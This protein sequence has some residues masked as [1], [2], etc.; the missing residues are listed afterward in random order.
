[1]LTEAIENQIYFSY[2]LLE[3]SVPPPWGDIWV[4]LQN[5]FLNLHIW[6]F[7][8][9]TEE[10]WAVILSPYFLVENSGKGSSA[11]EGVCREVWTAWL[12]WLIQG[13]AKSKQREGWTQ[14]SAFKNLRPSVGFFF[15][16]FEVNY[17][18]KLGVCGVIFSLQFAEE[19][20]L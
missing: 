6:E 3:N 1:M 9:C 10:N 16:F 14:L 5:Q 15:F 8:F 12:E 17:G 19:T 4:W 20:P 18:Q 2:S 13:Q 11:R 7:S